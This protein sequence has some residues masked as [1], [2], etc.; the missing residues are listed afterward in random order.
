MT[1]AQSRMARAALNWSPMDL[2]EHSGADPA[3]IHRFETGEA[4]GPPIA[5]ALRRAFEAE[6]VRFLMNGE[7]AGGV[8]P[9]QPLPGVGAPNPIVETMIGQARD[10]RD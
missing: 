6:R 1:P 4:A 9:P 5:N 10:G 2:A 8:V 7:F 3:A